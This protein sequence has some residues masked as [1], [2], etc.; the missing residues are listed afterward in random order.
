MTPGL[1]E[2]LEAAGEHTPGP[3]RAEHTGYYW[4]VSSAEGT[5]T[6]ACPSQFIGGG[7]IENPSPREKANA[8]LIA[9]AP[10]LLEALQK[11]VAL[12]DTFCAR[13]GNQED[14]YNLVATRWADFDAARA[15]ILKA[16]ATQEQG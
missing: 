7:T 2:R 6:D 3:W 16:R 12:H 9:A 5:V 13:H 8:R 1:I 10:D 4:Q 15:A 11:L 14:A